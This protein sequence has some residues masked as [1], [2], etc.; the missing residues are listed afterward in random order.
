MSLRKVIIAVPDDTGP[1]LAEAIPLRHVFTEVILYVSS[2][3]SHIT[4]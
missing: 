4:R 2:Q 3:I 1:E